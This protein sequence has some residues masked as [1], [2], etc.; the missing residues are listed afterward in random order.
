MESSANIRGK[1]YGISNVFLQ[2]LQWLSN[3]LFKKIYVK[4][5]ENDQILQFYDILI[6]NLISVIY[7]L[8]NSF[9]DDKKLR[10]EFIL[11]TQ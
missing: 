1:M 10:E 3:I 11:D 6:K 9:S 2:K 4:N 5:M 8:I 7:R